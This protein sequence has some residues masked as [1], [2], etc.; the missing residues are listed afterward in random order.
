MGNECL[1]KLF[2]CRYATEKLLDR[3]VVF[4]LGLTFYL[5]AL[6]SDQRGLCCSEEG[7]D[8]SESPPIGRY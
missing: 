1:R 4:C 8:T 6:V 5:F 2:E 7:S 3:L